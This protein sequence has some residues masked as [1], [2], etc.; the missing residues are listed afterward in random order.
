MIA[1]LRHDRLA[2]ALC[3]SMALIVTSA[4]LSSMRQ[5]FTLKRQETS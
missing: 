1:A 2:M 3:V 4:R 5:Y